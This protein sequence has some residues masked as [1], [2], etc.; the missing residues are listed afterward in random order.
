MTTHL[1]HSNLN[2]KNYLLTA[3]KSQKPTFG[4]LGRIK[5]RITNRLLR[6]AE[7]IPQDQRTVDILG[8]ERP[9]LDMVEDYNR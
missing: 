3:A 8:Y 6:Y 2:T 5:V 1:E 7:K 4:L 9:L